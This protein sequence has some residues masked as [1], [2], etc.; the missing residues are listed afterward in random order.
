MSYIASWIVAAL[1]VFSLYTKQYTFATLYGVLFL[2]FLAQY[3]I[4]SIKEHIDSKFK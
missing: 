1:L 2:F 3:I 4:A